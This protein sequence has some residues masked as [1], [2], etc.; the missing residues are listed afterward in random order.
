MTRQI[1]ATE[2]LASTLRREI[3]PGPHVTGDAGIAEWVR[4]HVVPQAIQHAAPHGTSADR[5][6]TND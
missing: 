5:C 3:H 4:E 1:A 6:S 2:P